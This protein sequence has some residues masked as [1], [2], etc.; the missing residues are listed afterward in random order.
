MAASIDKRI[1]IRK[2]DTVTIARVSGEIGRALTEVG[3]VDSDA[4]G[5]LSIN[6]RM[7]AKDPAKLHIS[8]SSSATIRYQVSRK[9]LMK[10]EP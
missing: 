10:G 9:R 7:R 3:A 5:S 4:R 8:R 1:D 6:G 2:L